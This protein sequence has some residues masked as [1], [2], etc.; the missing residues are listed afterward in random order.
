[1]PMAAVAATVENQ[2]AR[3]GI[4]TRTV[5]VSTSSIGDHRHHIIGGKI[6]AGARHRAVPVPRT[7]MIGETVTGIAQR[8][9]DRFGLQRLSRLK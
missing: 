1:M 8:L 7:G 5:E 9:L 2:R 6:E 4:E 3:Q